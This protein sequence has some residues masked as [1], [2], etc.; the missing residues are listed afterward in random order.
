MNVGAEALKG[1]VALVGAGPGDPDLLTLKAARLIKLAT[2]I[3]Y[4]R[5]VSPAIMAMVNPE[6]EQI[7]VGKARSNHAMPQDKI[8]QTLADYAKQGHFVV[9]LK[10]G[11]PFIFGRGGEELEILAAQQVPFQV[12][13]GITA[14]AGCSTYA[15]IPLTH[16]DYAQSV[17]FVTGHVKNG[18]VD[19]NG[20]EYINE[21]ETLVV[22][23]G[24]VGLSQ[25]TARLIE[26]GRAPTTPVALIQQ[27]TTPN[28]KVVVADLSSISEVVAS[29]DIKP[30]T[31]VIIGG[32]VGLKDQLSWF[33]AELN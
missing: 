10:G 22:Y 23:M 32:V 24:L 16:R 7:Y 15:G 4:D 9:R 28:Q 6:A 33:K 17:R 2:I 27:G 20:I 14:A 1:T 8:N 5:L 29:H 12:V 21:N 31:L 26:L 19:L 3:F 11:D 18:V 30:P 25:I 13:P